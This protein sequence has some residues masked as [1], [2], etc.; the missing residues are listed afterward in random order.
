MGMIQLGVGDLIKRQRESLVGSFSMKVYYHWIELDPKE[1]NVKITAN[2]IKE[3]T[4]QEPE[5]TP[6]YNH[7]TGQEYFD[8]RFQTTHELSED[9]CDCLGS[10][11]V[12]DMLLNEEA[13][14]E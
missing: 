2:Y 1:G 10:Q 14:E 7:D 6:E 3:V 4:G 11:G 13:E 9:V 5:C 8:I 12:F